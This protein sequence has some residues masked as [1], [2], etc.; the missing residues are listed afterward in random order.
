MIHQKI[1]FD[2]STLRLVNYSLVNWRKGLS[3]VNH[4]HQYYLLKESILLKAANREDYD[5][6]YK[7][8]KTSCY[9]DDIN[10]DRLCGSSTTTYSEKIHQYAQYVM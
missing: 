6:D 8:A 1:I 4:C 7:L 5:I 3:N 10:F 9:K 2:M